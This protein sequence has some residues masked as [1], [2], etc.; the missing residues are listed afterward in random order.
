MLVVFTLKSPRKVR[1]PVLKRNTFTSHHMDK[2]KHRHVLS[3]VVHRVPFPIIC[4]N[5]FMSWPLMIVLVPPTGYWID[6]HCV[7]LLLVII[8]ICFPPQER[9]GGMI[10][11]SIVI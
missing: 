7:L 6:F 9:S 1:V 8:R 5:S 2:Y 4:E 3:F 10:E 11:R